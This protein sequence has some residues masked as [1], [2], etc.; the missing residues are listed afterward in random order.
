MILEPSWWCR[1]SYK[2]EEGNRITGALMW[3]KWSVHFH[4]DAW[5]KAIRFESRSVRARAWHQNHSIQSSISQSRWGSDIHTHKK[6][7]SLSTTALH[8][9]H[10]R[11]FRPSLQSYPSSEIPTVENQEQDC[12]N[13]SWGVC[14]WADLFLSSE[15]FWALNHIKDQHPC[16]PVSLQTARE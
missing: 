5:S 11:P 1:S 9:L 14:L 2:R 16:L 15:L 8:S 3:V 13:Q 12:L 4:Y 7:L 6:V 10:R